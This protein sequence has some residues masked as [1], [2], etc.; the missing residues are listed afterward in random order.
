MT[1]SWPVE[2]M[3]LSRESSVSW[4]LND[5]L[6]ADRKA[7]EF[8]A[9]G[10]SDIGQAPS[11]VS[12]FTQ[13]SPTVVDVGELTGEE[14]ID[15]LEEVDN[16]DISPDL[17]Q[18]TEELLSEPDN[19][20]PEECD[21]S[22]REEEEAAESFAAEALDQAK[23][24]AYDEG[25]SKGRN[26]AEQEYK[27]SKEQLDALITSIRA[28]QQDMTAFYQPMKKLS[29][30]LAQQ[31]V[32][33]EL[34]LSSS[35]IERLTKG[36]LDDL[37]YQGEGPIIV[38][39]HPADRDNF[40]DELY[41]DFTSLELRVDRSLSQGSVKISVDDTAIE[42]LI[43]QRLDKLS[44]QVLGISLPTV[45]VPRED[46]EQFK[47]QV[48]EHMIEASSLDSGGYVDQVVGESD[49]SDTDSIDADPHV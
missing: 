44:Q 24:E 14:L 12:A 15:T 42:D 1:L 30:H 47:N 40:G 28:A 43:E 41:E 10:W 16:D 32:R 49:T 19:Q 48:Q 21:D 38:Y 45:S 4:R 18:E 35:A 23:R 5:L 37:E 36:A 6:T 9:A 3:T 29:L 11:T 7:K 8:A 34:T 26:V 17:H 22:S 31:L 46:T 25:Y 33:G 20:K 39:L 2:G 13:W 27:K